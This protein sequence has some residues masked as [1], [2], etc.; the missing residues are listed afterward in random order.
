MIEHRDP[1][2][3]A[4]SSVVT[5]HVSGLSTAYG[6]T[7][8]AEIS[9]PLRRAHELLRGRYLWAILLTFAGLLLGGIAGYK[10]LPVKYTSY[11]QL[12]VAPRIDRILAQTEENVTIMPMFGAFVEA[13]MST[14]TSRRVVD[15]AMSS[16]AWRSLGR[17]STNAMVR[18]FA[19]S[20]SVDHQR[21]GQ[22][23]DV[24]FTDVDPRVAEVG[25]QAVIEAYLRVREE[26]DAQTETTRIR[27]LQ[28]LLTQLTNQERAISAEIHEI[29]SEFGTD[30]LELLHR[31]KID[32]LH[33]RQTELRTLELALAS[34]A[35]RSEQ[36]ADQQSSSIGQSPEQIALN[37]EDMR[38]YLRRRRYLE[39][40]V[41]ALGAK[42]GINH[43]L[44][45]DPQRSLDALN[46]IIARYAEQ[47]RRLH[48][49]T[50]SGTL[51]DGI[52]AMGMTFTTREQLEA[53]GTQLRK[54]VDDLLAETK[55]LGDKNVEIGKLKDERQR[56]EGDLERTR[57]RLN[58][59]NVESAV[60]GRITA[61]SKGDRPLYPSNSGRRKQ[62]AMLC[63][64]LGGS[65][66]A[67]VMLLLGLFD[68]RM[69]SSDDVRW[70]AQTM[71][72]LGILPNL[73]DNLTDPD[74]AAAAAYAVHH[75]RTML[76][77]SAGHKDQHV[78]AVTSPAPGTGKT[79]LT[80]ALGLSFAHCGL[81]TLIV[82]ADL[83]GAGLTTR[84]QA[85]VHPKIGHILRRAGLITADELE[86]AL[87]EAKQSGRKTGQILMNWGK[88]KAEDV[89]AALRRQSMEL[90]GLLDVVHG[91]ASLADCVQ[92]IGLEKLDILPVGS[93]TAQH[94]T[95]LTPS[96]VRK[97]I[98]TARERY[99]VILFD[100]GPI[101]GS[102]EAS[103][104]AAQV[105][106]VVL[107]V[108]RG[109]QRPLAIKAAEHLTAIGATLCGLV[110]NRADAEDVIRSSYASVYSRRMDGASTVLSLPPPARQDPQT[111]SMGPIATAVVSQTHASDSDSEH[112]DD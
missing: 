69:R 84:S 97:I 14:I 70:S 34:T 53:Y 75:V 56:V 85:A 7:D 10:L 77:L 25:V 90:L 28:S 87:R 37:D 111:R 9:H 96:A 2:L 62:L 79:S 104:V 110:F 18:Q 32:E 72:M 60:S 45:R 33:Q 35:S 99:D 100:T 65:L 106:G 82:D 86:H 39:R 108:S 46:S 94:A 102:I 66:G 26:L 16:D 30:T 74:Q 51:V 12:K 109:E 93:A 57:Q 103:I 64:F 63:A 58:D 13:E 49:T 101:L 36:T 8:G 31:A 29:A 98:L 20:L 43:R 83:V 40:D 27:T 80:F 71:R 24:S 81:K 4:V 22:T 6:R 95:T 38:E 5:D 44:V 112:S 52:G 17:G 68:P 54:T 21:N 91:K 23:I 19:E 1:N 89:D 42:Y 47:Y 48:A 105:E 88:L 41:A 107:T 78:F 59:L 92:Q 50:G 76:Q 11:G 55:A 61:I 15:L 73:P 67:S 3:T